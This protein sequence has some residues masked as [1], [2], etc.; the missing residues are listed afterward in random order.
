MKIFDDNGKKGRDLH[1]TT[2]DDSTGGDVSINDAEPPYTGTFQPDKPL[3]AFQSLPGQGEWKLL[4]VSSTAEIAQLL[5]W[6]L[7]LW[8]APLPVTFAN[9]LLT[10]G[11]PSSD[12]SQLSYAM[13][14]SKYSGSFTEPFLGNAPDRFG[15]VHSRWASPVDA[16]YTYER[17]SGGNWVPTVPETLFI[18]RLPGGRDVWMVD[19]G[20]SASTGIFRVKTSLSAP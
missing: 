6:T 17:L 1:R 11:R 4:I 2:F 18:T 19:F 9:Y 8:A 10:T 16:T 15:F 14:S 7:E 3:S 13:A 5:D 20:R 12:Q